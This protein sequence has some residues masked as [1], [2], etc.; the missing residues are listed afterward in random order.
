MSMVINRVMQINS[1]YLRAVQQDN[2]KV[3]LLSKQK[4]ASNF[5]LVEVWLLPENAAAITPQFLEKAT[6]NSIGNLLMMIGDKAYLDPL[7]YKLI[8]RF[9]PR[10]PVFESYL[11]YSILGVQDGHVI[12]IVFGS[13]NAMDEMYNHGLRERLT[14]PS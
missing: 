7:R 3:A 13:Q 4:I 11:H 12:S 2:S 9:L 10:L 5:Q 6:A 8:D 14:A 1:V